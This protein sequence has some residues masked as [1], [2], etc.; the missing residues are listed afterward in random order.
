MWNFYRHPAKLPVREPSFL[1]VWWQD[2][3]AAKRLLEA[4]E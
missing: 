1:R 4:R 3:A 2:E